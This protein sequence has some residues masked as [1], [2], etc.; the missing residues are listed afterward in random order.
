MLGTRR[1]RHVGAS[2][3]RDHGTPVTGGQGARC[4]VRGTTP[5]RILQGPRLHNARHGKRPT[6]GGGPRAGEGAHPGEWEV[7]GRPQSSWG[8]RPPGAGEQVAARGKGRSRAAC[9]TQTTRMGTRGHGPVEV[10]DLQRHRRRRATREPPQRF[11]DRSALRTPHAWLAQAYAPGKTQTGAPTP[12][13]D[14]VTRRLLRSTWSTPWRRSDRSATRGRV[15]R[16]R[17]DGPRGKRVKPLDASKSAAAAC[18]LVAT[19]WSKRDVGCAWHRSMRRIAAAPRR[20]AGPTGVRRMRCPLGPPV[21]TMVQ[22]MAGPLRAIGGPV[23]RQ[24]D[25]AR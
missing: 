2:N 4:G 14:G 5:G 16:C 8:G 6:C 11:G 12:G 24:C 19:G 10:G 25:P 7:A 1:L 15:G 20:A 9:L 3:P 23:A 21:C 17:S 22:A 18:P 13:G